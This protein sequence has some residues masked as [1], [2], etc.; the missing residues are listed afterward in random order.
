[1]KNIEKKN[2]FVESVLS[3]NP[4]KFPLP[5]RMNNN[6]RDILT[7]IIKKLESTFETNLKELNYK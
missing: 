6:W 7:E 3:K 2:G 1:M 4:K 5:F